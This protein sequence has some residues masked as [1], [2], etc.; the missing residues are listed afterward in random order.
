MGAKL[1]LTRAVWTEAWGRAYAYALRLKHPKHEA[2]DFAQ[3]AIVA[4]LDP[5]KSEWVPLAPV[6]FPSHVCNLLWSAH[7]NHVQS[8]A[9]RNASFPL[10]EEALDSQVDARDSHVVLL[11]TRWAA[12]A[13]AR[14]RALLDRV[15]GD[16]LVSLLLAD[17]KGESSTKRAVAA[18]HTLDE[19][20][21]ARKRLKRHIRA[22]VL[23][24]PT[25]AGMGDDED[26]GERKAP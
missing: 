21:A 2:E 1:W 23:Q 3:G 15:A 17:G 25:P 22:V 12:F 26:E 14:Y 6:D 8:Y 24:M 16:A 5:A 4:A 11:E 19:I 10:T 20:E 7:G 18:G 9:V 13:E